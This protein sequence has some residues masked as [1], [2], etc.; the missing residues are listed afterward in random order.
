M[1]KDGEEEDKA[2]Q[3]LLMKQNPEKQLTDPGGVGRQGNLA[4]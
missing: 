2:E 4:S 1:K 3:E